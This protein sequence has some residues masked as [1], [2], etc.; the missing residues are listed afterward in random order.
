MSGTLKISACDFSLSSS[1]R[2]NRIFNFCPVQIAYKDV[3]FYGMNPERL[4][5]R[6]RY[7]LYPPR[8]VVSIDGSSTTR[9]AEV[10]FTFSGALTNKNNDNL[11][12]PMQL[13]P[14]FPQPIMQGSYMYNTHQHV[15][16][17]I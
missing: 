3:D 2:N 17:S 11:K 10:N 9:K 13:L 7:G 4:K 6:E 1:Y 16:T 8:F 12:Y 14:Q 15:Y 5:A